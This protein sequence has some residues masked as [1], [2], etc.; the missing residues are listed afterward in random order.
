MYAVRHHPSPA[1]A[2]AALTCGSCGSALDS[3][4][5][6]QAAA[7]V[8][9]AESGVVCLFCGTPV[10]SVEQAGRSPAVGSAVGDVLRTMRL[11]DRISLDQAAAETCIRRSYLEALEND[12]PPPEYP[13]PVY[14]RFFLGDYAAYLGLDPGPL[15]A[16]FDRDLASEVLESEGPPSP[17]PARRRSLPWSVAAM[18]SSVVLVVGIILTR[19]QSPPAADL[20]SI[21]SPAAV[22][23]AMP[24]AAAGDPTPA[25][26]SAPR[27]SAQPADARAPGPN[28]HAVLSAPGRSVL[29]PVIDGE[30]RR[31]RLV[32]RSQ[33][34]RFEADR[35]LDLRLTDGRRAVVRVNGDRVAMRPGGPRDVSFVVRHGRVV[36]RSAAG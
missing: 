35:S 13:G 28:I 36:Q 17:L 32:R 33:T 10:P 3:A 23:S 20:A 16:T 14:A 11:N 31:E 1:V 26:A 4:H 29:E 6:E 25:G 2:G 8:D 15:L 21:G 18:I 24:A 12:E 22:A 19:P 30:P 7:C 34:V 27:E 9:Q 5:V